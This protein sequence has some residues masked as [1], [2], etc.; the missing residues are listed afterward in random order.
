MSILTINQNRWFA[1]GG[2]QNKQ[3]EFA[4]QDESP[5]LYDPTYVPCEESDFDVDPLDVR[6]RQP[7]PKEAFL[8]RDEV[9]IRTIAILEGMERCKTDG[10]TLTENTHLANDLALDS[11]DQVEFGLAV[12][13]EFDVDIPDEEAD[14]IVTVGDVVE[15][16]ADHPWAR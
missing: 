9:L 8:P 4:S 15:L 1:S 2:N 13:D 10:I 12:E 16:I 11:L 3:D 14:Q 5:H 6:L 7:L